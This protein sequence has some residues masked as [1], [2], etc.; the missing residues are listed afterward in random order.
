RLPI[1]WHG[2][3][4][5]LKGVIAPDFIADLLGFGQKSQPLG[6][7]LNVVS[8]SCVVKPFDPASRRVSVAFADEAE[9]TAGPP[10]R[11]CAPNG[12]SCQRSR[13]TVNF[14]GCSR[15]TK[16]TAGSPGE[17]PFPPRKCPADQS[18]LA[19]GRTP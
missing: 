1:S 2:A 14:C 13:P 9:H 3:F 18:F 12:C 5:H 19:D 8:P 16:S 11:R 6:F 7:L 17:K 15:K 10:R 4:D